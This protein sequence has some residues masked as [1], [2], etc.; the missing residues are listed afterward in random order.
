LDTKNLNIQNLNSKIE[1]VS[2]AGGWDQL[3]AAVNSGADA[4]YLGYKK[5]G[6]RAYAE[7]FDLN[8]LK[9]AVL[10]A[11]KNNV[12]IYLTL[13]TLLKDSEFEEVLK[14]LNEYSG[15]CRDG[16]II[17]D[18]GLYK[19]IKDLY[20]F[21]RIHASTQ[22]N[23]H[24]FYTA[25]L[26]QELNFSRVVLAREMT[27]EEIKSITDKK[28]LEIEVFAHGSQCYSYS[29]SCYLSSSTG[30]RSGNRGR[31]TQ[32]C[33]MRY[34]LICETKDNHKQ[35]EKPIKPIICND[36]YL[37]SKSDL[38]TLEIL[39]DLIKAG[40]SALK[41]EGRMK[42]AD[43]V[44]IVTKIYR[45]YIDL[46][47]KNTDK[48]TVSDEDIYKIAQIFSRELGPGYFKEKYPSDIVSLKKSGSIGNFLGR[49]FDMD[50]DKPYGKTG[51]VKGQVKTIY[52][53]SKW[54]INNGDIIEIWTNKGNEQLKVSNIVFLKKEQGKNV[55]KIILNKNISISNGDRVFKYFDKELDMEAKKLYQ[56]DSTNAIFA[57]AKLTGKIINSHKIGE[58]GGKLKEENLINYLNKY[59]YP[60]SRK[61]KNKKAGSLKRNCPGLSVI[62]YDK[63]AA[64]N[65]VDCGANRIIYSNFSEIL[66]A[67][68]NGI[69][70][71]GKV[72]KYCDRHG[73][74]FVISIPAILYDSEI[75]NLKR[76]FGNYMNAGIRNFKISNP[77]FL[78][79]VPGDCKGLYFNLYLGSTLN[80]F[81]TF[82]LSCFMDLLANS[83]NKIKGADLSPE[84]SLNEI[85]DILINAKNFT[86]KNF[87]FSIY[88]YG[89]YPIMSSRYKLS[90]LDDSYSSERG[91][92]ISD[93]KGYKFRIC[94]NYNES[95]L[96]FNSRKICLIFDLDKIVESGINI[97]EVDTRF[98]T[99]NEVSKVIKSF[100]KAIDILTT[101]GT[102]KYREFIGR[103][104]D[105]ILFRNYTKGHLMRSVL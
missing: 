84:L 98:M 21:L 39:P 97:I 53:K 85:S 34:K 2:P 9:K 62:V 105:E 64:S 47:Y 68:K 18:F 32:P 36:G 95:I 94:S 40:I 76:N 45:K 37:L 38:C 28:I 88:G 54:N 52:I 100:K 87:E 67:G 25:E 103:L 1:L 80:I 35:I 79:L 63:N 82:A 12:K 8:Q 26:L 48:Y 65:A 86:H 92:Y 89:Y 7:N 10:F 96:I 13:N 51:K 90:Y 77:G 20:P 66:K 23:V 83:G 24:S 46:Y 3:K 6:A 71:I 56:E 43:Y 16:I 69:S 93:S 50:F 75:E 27:L 91:Y 4:V 15:I 30:E 49:I 19:A 81:N 29:G 61:F 60:Y 74:D 57:D 17:Q 44:G 42:S 58:G 14:F 22:L 101:Q 73:V 104:T 5:F 31:C 11:H 59:T 41:L 99:D 55:Y 102:E 78:K 33:R 72:K 70:D